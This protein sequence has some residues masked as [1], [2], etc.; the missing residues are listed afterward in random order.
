M[1]TRAD[2]VSLAH[3]KITPPFTLDETLTLFCPQENIEALEHPAVC[4]LHSMLTDYR[5][6]VEGKRAAMLLLP[7][8]KTKPYSLSD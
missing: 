2:R 1:P 3:G 5:P 7:C 6:P 8:T 4:T